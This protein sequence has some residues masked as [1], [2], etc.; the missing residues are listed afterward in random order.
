MN[1][2]NFE[3]YLAPASDIA[4]SAGALIMRYFTA[5]FTTSRKQDKSPVT[6]AD[7]AANRYIVEALAKLAP[8]I[9]IVAEEDEELTK[10]E[11]ELF[12]LVDPLDGTRSFINGE[13]EFTVNIGLIQHG[14]PVLGV[15]YL[16]PTELM[17]FAGERAYRSIAGSTPE[18]IHARKPEEEGLVVVSSKAFARAETQEFLKSIKVKELVPGSSSIKFCQVAEGSA[19]LYP[20]FGRTMEWDTAA[21]HA[22]L[23]AAGGRVETWDGK[24]L[25]Y[26][27]PHFENP[28]FIAYGL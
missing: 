17:Y 3:E 14:K 9:P 26:G 20:R 2:I 1:S 27:K 12:W 10:D 21:G 5:G 11:H 16:P 22:I 13:P 7:I 18:I 25:L 6:D 4:R 8:S 19:D 15:I 28:N 23:N 24:P